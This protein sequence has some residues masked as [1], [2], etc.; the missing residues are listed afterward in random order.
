MNPRP[1]LEVRRN[2]C[3][4]LVGGLHKP[5]L[6]GFIAVELGWWATLAETEAILE[7]LVKDGLLR[8]ITPKEASACGIRH[9]YVLLGVED[10]SKMA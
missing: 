4:T 5:A 1:P 10:A 8:R 2:R 3:M 7:G 6:I 9:G